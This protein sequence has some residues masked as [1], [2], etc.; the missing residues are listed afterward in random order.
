[1]LSFYD[2]KVMLSISNVLLSLQPGV[3]KIADFECAKGS[4]FQSAIGNLQFAL[5]PH[6]NYFLFKII[7]CFCWAG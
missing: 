3:I 4:I 1:M 7:F 6:V 2:K 5:D